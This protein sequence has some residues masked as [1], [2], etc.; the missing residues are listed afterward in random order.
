MNIYTRVV[1]INTILKPAD[2]HADV[3]ST[4]FFFFN[5]GGGKGVNA[6]GRRLALYNCPGPSF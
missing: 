4:V 5:G 3:I 2:S 6:E 1:S